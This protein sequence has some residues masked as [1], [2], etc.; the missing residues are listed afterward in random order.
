[1]AGSTGRGLIGRLGDYFK[2]LIG[3]NE[4]IKENTD[5]F[6]FDPSGNL[7]VKDT[8]DDADLGEI[9]D[10]LQELNGKVSTEVTLDLALDEL[11]AIELTLDGIKAKT[12][13]MQFV[14]GKLRTTGEDAAGG[15]GGSDVFG[16]TG[17]RATTGLT[18]SS[19]SIAAA[20]TDR[21]Q[22]MIFNTTGKT[23]WVCYGATA[24]F[25]EGIELDKKDFIIEDKYRG[26]ITAIMDTG[27]TGNIQTTTVTV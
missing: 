15:G 1:M 6:T 19:T 18:D 20:D 21:K 14:S 3:I 16:D 22:I 2:D 12:D 5:K 13:Q 10:E 9:I 27:Q 8:G 23:I 26:Q 24:V 25:G 11:Q 17:S 4:D 7:C